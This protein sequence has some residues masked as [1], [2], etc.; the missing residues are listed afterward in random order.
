MVYH[1]GMSTSI[2]QLAQLAGISI[3][4]L[5]YYD[6]IGLLSP[7]R[8]KSND[9]RRYSDADLSTLQQILIYRELGIPLDQVKHILVSPAFDALQALEE[10]KAALERR[11]EQ[12]LTLIQTV[13]NTIEHMK[14]KIEMDNKDMFL[15]FSYEEQKKYEK[16]AR[17]RWGD[18]KVD[19]TMKR[20]NSYTKEQQKKILAEGNEIYKSMAANMDKGPGSP[21]VQ[22]LVARWHKNLRHFYE[23][24]KERLLGLAQLYNDH[25]GFQKTFHKFHPDLAGFMKQAVEIYVKKLK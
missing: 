16:E 4:T 22:A 15:G 6:E 19:P 13:E 20:W 2:K 24:D 10:H 11:T 7:A 12:T 14:G 8:E 1:S 3:R 5:H 25:P 9:Y 21:E 23:P 18:N 17:E